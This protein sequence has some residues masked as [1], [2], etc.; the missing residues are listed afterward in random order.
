[1]RL[2]FC[3]ACVGMKFDSPSINRVIH[4][5]PQRHIV[6][7]IQQIGRAERAYQKSKA[8][9]NFNKSDIAYHVP[10]ITDAIID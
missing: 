4:A 6:D 10:D 9:L 3:T 1:M 7:Y 8:I 5:K 2:L